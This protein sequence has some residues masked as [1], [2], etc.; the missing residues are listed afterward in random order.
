MQ[1]YCD[2]GYIIHTVQCLVHNWV[3]TTL[4]C[5]SAVF[6]FFLFD[7]LVHSPTET[8][9]NSFQSS[10]VPS[11]PSYS[12]PSRKPKSSCQWFIASSLPGCPDA[13]PHPQAQDLSVLPWD[14]SCCLSLRELHHLAPLPV[15]LWTMDFSLPCFSYHILV[16]FSLACQ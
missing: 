9:P 2:E 16:A 4:Q 3:I 13:P 15:P 6:P 8:T 1:G 10:K 14:I 12:Q 7:S 5:D 11:L